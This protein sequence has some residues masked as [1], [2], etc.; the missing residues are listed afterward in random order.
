MLSNVLQEASRGIVLG[1][2]DG[3]GKGKENQ[4]CSKKLLQ[5]Q[6]SRDFSEHGAHMP[7]L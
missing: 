6:I 2:G 1:G 5:G 4:T 7:P 3:E